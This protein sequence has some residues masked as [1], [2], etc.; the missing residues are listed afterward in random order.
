MERKLVSVKVGVNLD[1]GREYLKCAISNFKATQNQGERV[2]SQLSYEQIMWSSHEETNSIAIIIKHLHG[3]MRSRWT[4]FL[5]SDGEK[6]DRNRDGEFEGGYNSKQEA[7]AAWQEGWEHVFKTMNTITPEHLLKTVY[8][9]G[10]AHTVM[11]AIERQISHYALHIGQIIYIGK[12]LKENEW[13]CLSIPRGQ[14]TSYLEKK[15][16]T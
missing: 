11:Q 14:S 13:E 15:R 2:L 12:M 16:S 10:E 1:I 5:T 7:L 9:R 3:N 8:I 4:D 6:T